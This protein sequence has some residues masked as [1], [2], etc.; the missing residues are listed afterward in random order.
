ME[1][2]VKK[3]EDLTIPLIFHVTNAIYTTKPEYGTHPEA[4]VFDLT[5]T[6]PYAIFKVENKKNREIKQI[7]FKGVANIEVGD[8]IVAYIRKYNARQ[9]YWNNCWRK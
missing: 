6:T 4:F 8:K 3:K 1:K 2:K 5:G 9:R 7:K